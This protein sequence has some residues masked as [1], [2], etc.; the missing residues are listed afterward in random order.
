MISEEQLAELERLEKAATMGPWRASRGYENRIIVNLVTDINQA[1]SGVAMIARLPELDGEGIRNALLIEAMRNNFADLLAEVRRLQR[2]NEVNMAVI[3]QYNGNPTQYWYR[4]FEV[5]KQHNAELQR[6][7]NDVL[8]DEE[9]NTQKRAE[10]TQRNAVLERT[11]E[12]KD[13]SIEA[14]WNHS[15]NGV[16]VNYWTT[17]ECI[18]QAEA[19]LAQG[20]NNG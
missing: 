17:E 5:L 10:L 7:Y 3:D 11:L 1:S 13:T 16:D 6:L 18:R 15:T 2:V 14:F 9:F 8:E 19:E 4:E 12:I 20:K